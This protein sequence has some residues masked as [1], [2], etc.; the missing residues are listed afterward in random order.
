[1]EEEG[2]E[3]WEEVVEEEQ[4]EVEENCPKRHDPIRTAVQ[5]TFGSPTT[6]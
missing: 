1:M 4:E 5:P 3:G 6:S 2:E